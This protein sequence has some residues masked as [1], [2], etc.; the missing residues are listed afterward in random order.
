[1]STTTDITPLPL[2]MD[3]TGPHAGVVVLRLEQ[4]GSPV[5]VLDEAL[6]R[7]LEGTLQALPRAMTGLVLASASSKVF[8][9]G[10]D[11]KT[12]QANA[13]DRDSDR[14]LD[15]YLAYGQRVFGMLAELQVP[16]CAAISGAALGGGLELAMHCDGLIGA[17]NA[18]GKPY[19][20]G[21]PEAGLSICPG[22]G[23]TNL[24]PAR[25]DSLDGIRRTAVGKPMMY[26]E[27]VAAKMFDAVAPGEAEL[28]A[29]AKAWAVAARGRMG[30]PGGI[31]RRDGA[32]SRW[33]GRPGMRAGVLAALARIGEEKLETESAR[34]VLDAVRAGLDRGWQAALDLERRELT[35]LR[36]TPAGRAAIQAFF[37]KGKK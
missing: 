27:A 24:L 23:G 7:R 16:T 21:L 36:N 14:K 13:A 5:V 29:T 17:P 10:A 37:D 3:E 20:I 4:P 1:M 12:I 8:V 11:L 18:S 26:D 19:P 25:I 22:W 30:Q 34:A 35:R 33:I 31:P 9:A 28:L 2:S 32:P 15:A 6:I